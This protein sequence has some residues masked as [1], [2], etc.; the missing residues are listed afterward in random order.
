[1]NFAIRTGVGTYTFEDANGDSLTAD[2]TGQAQGG[3]IVSIVEHAVV[4]ISMA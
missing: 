1:V 4:S 2:F 3:P